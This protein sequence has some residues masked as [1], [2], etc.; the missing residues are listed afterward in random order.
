MTRKGY[1][2]LVHLLPGF[3]FRSVQH[4]VLRVT[5]QIASVHL[6][7][8]VNCVAAKRVVG[9]RTPIR[10]ELGSRYSGNDIRLR[11]PGMGETALK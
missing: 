7:V 5:V 4:G 11:A 8:S 1:C 9:H 6:L 10:G 3:G 2:G